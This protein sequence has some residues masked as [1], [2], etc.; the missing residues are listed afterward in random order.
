MQTRQGYIHRAT[1]F[2]FLVRLRAFEEFAWDWGE[3]GTDRTRSRSCERWGG[4]SSTWF[5]LWVCGPPL[6]R[7]LAVA[8]SYEGGVRP[9]VVHFGDA[10]IVGTLGMWMDAA[11]SAIY[12][13]LMN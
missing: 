5:R 6:T 11:A 10:G 8:G 7:E 13:F 3:M 12:F 9:V 2:L 1:K 4:T